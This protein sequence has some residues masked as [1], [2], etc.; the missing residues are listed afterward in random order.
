MTGEA[1]AGK[2]TLAAALVRPELTGGRVPSDFVQAVS[3]LVQTTNQ[4]SLATDLERQL[5]R[6]VPAFAEAVAEFERTCPAR[7]ARNA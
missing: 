3:F 1:G 7:G 5:R 4:R 6:A 2:S